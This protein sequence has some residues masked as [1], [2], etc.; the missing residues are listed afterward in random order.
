MHENA[1]MPSLAQIQALSTEDKIELLALLQEKERRQRLRQRA[2][3]KAT[4]RKERK[5][6]V[7]CGARRKTDGQPCEAKSEPDKRRC[8]FHGGCST[9]PKTEEGKA[10]ALANLRGQKPTGDGRR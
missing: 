2:E 6:R 7:V 10:R 1:P 5:K 3:R 9:G 8:R 4:R